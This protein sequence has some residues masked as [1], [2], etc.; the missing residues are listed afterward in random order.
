[1]TLVLTLIWM[2]GFR[3]YDDVDTGFWHTLFW[4]YFLGKKL[5]TWTEATPPADGEG[6]K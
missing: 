2:G 3:Y 6:R 5:A 4:P 1:M